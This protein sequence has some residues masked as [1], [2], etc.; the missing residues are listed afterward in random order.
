[1]K[2]WALI[3]RL[4]AMPQEAEVITNC[5]QATTEHEDVTDL[6]EICVLNKEQVYVGSENKY[7]T[8]E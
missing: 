5:C 1:M 8:G 3:E 2:V 7:L 4:K 6:S